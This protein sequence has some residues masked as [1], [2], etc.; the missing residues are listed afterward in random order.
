MRDDNYFII[1]G[2][3]SGAANGLSRFFWSALL[4]YISPNT[5]LFINICLIIILSSTL[6]VIC[7]NKINY[8]IWIVLIYFQYGGLFTYFPTI[9]TKVILLLINLIVILY[10]SNLAPRSVH[11]HTILYSLLSS[12]QTSHNFFWFCMQRNIL[13]IKEYSKSI[14]FLVLLP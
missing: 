3:L 11:M 14:L 4:D 10:H 2:S 6:N 1:V 9:C 13:D 5:L 12:I 7:H 8:C